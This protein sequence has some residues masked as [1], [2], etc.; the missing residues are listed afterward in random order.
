MASPTFAAAGAGAASVS[1]SVAVPYP[2]SLVSGDLLVLHLATRGMG[3]L[4]V[5]SGWTS[6][7]SN[8]SATNVKEFALYKWSTGTETGTQNVT[9]LGGFASRGEFGRMYRFSNPKQTSPFEGTGSSTGTSATIADQTVTTTAA[10][11]I[12]VNLVALA[13][14]QTIGAFSGESGGTW[15]EAVSEYNSASG[16][17]ITMQ[18]QT[19]D[20]PST[21]TIDGGTVSVGTSGDFVVIGFAILPTPALTPTMGEVTETDTVFSVAVQV[22]PAGLHPTMGEVTETDTVYAVTAVLTPPA[23][24]DLFFGVDFG[25][26][27]EDLARLAD[28][29]TGENRVASLRVVRGR[30]TNL[31]TMQAG[32]VQTVFRNGTDAAGNDGALL[33]P[34]NVNSRLYGR[35]LPGLPTRVARVRNGV[36]YEVFR[37]PVERWEPQW[38]PPNYQDMGMEASDSFRTLSKNTIVSD[39]STFTTNLTGANNDLTFTARDAG[40]QGDDI[41]VT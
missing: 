9:F 32:Q 26:G 8:T 3:A 38:V 15:V 17:G 29:A 2:S 11:R 16:L 20:M 24:N 37:G 33:D 27:Y 19:A 6:L 12:A 41:T 35:I 18:L 10:S 22:T 36:V 23:D 30:T 34:S 14:N 21:G 39:K 13:S 25:S 7:T 4:S 28:E 5:P 31:D 40:G 1:G